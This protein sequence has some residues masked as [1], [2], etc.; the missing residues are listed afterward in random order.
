MFKPPKRVLWHE[1]IYTY[2]CGPANE[3]LEGGPHI[4]F[5]S[6]STCSLTLFHMVLLSNTNNL[7]NSPSLFYVVAQIY[8][9]LLLYCFQY[10]LVD[11]VTIQTLEISIVPKIKNVTHSLSGSSATCT[12]HPSNDFIRD[13][14]RK[15]EALLV[16][17]RSWLVSTMTL[18]TKGQIKNTN[19]SKLIMLPLGC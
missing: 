2:I 12:Y 8:L 14:W 10:W 17:V 19:E 7:T 5:R 15:Q 16:L 1:K 13:V 6:I 3:R 18:V 11:L 9:L 4:H